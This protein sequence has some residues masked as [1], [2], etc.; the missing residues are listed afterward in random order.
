MVRVVV[1]L[2]GFF[3]FGCVGEASV[4]YKGTVTR[5]PVKSGYTF[6]DEPNPAGLQPIAG[7]AISL[8]ACESPSSHDATSNNNGRWGPIDTIFGG[9]IGV[10]TPIRVKVHA[11]GFEDLVYKTTYE[12]TN[13]PTNRDEFLNVR[14]KA[15]AD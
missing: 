1:A 9:F 5:S 15:L 13:D 8:C 14:L 2:T 4:T 7:A 12:S 6:D 11:K 10:D 3:V